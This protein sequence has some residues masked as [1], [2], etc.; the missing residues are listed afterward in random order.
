MPEKAKGKRLFT[1]IMDFEGTTSAAQFRT[2]S[3]QDALRLWLDGLIQPDSYGLTNLQRTR[4]AEG[5]N[6]FDLGLAPAPLQGLSEH[7]VFS[8]FGQG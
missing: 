2:D 1:A 6:D 7:M 4:L 5:C 8:S 3:V